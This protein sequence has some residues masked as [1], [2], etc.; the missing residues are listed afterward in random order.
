LPFYLWRQGTQ[1]QH[2][3]GASRCIYSTWTP[4]GL[5]A[6][7]NE[8]HFVL[9]GV[10]VFERRIYWLTRRLNE[11]EQSY[12]PNRSESVEFHA[13]VIRARRE[14]PWTSMPRSQRQQ[15]MDDVYS[16]IADENYPGLV[17]FAAA[18]HK[19]SLQ[20]GERALSRAFEEVCRRFDLF[21]RRRFDE[22]DT[23]RG[24]VIMDACRIAEKEEF[25]AL[26]TDYIGGG[27]RWGRFHNLTDIPFFA[28]SC[29]TRM[30]Q[31]ADFCS[32][33][34]YRR[35]E[36]GDTSYLDKIID[37]F[38][39]T[40]GVIHGLFHLTANHRSCWCPACSSRR[41]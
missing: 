13:S 14:E 24:L 26:W 10:A 4:P 3:V 38:D 40:G 7:L 15:V 41:G 35:Y 19:P 23:Q 18:I 17:A 8:E 12:F 25:R 32:Y 6:A 39:Q 31:L 21:L 33:A 11:I 20:H 34:V 36:S 27:T 22:E 16:T 1:N 5:Q 30:L 2:E 37:R 28:D 29:A 9:G